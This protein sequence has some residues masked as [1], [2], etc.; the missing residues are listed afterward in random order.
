M[1]DQQI[2]TSDLL[3][4]IKLLKDKVTAFESGE[5]YQQIQK[6][7]RRIVADRDRQ[8]RQLKSELAEAH[9]ETVD[10][11]NRWFQTCEDIT[12]EKEAALTAKDRELKKMEKRM[13]EAEHQR[14][15]YKDKLHQ[16]TLEL[17]AAQTKVEELQGTIQKLTAEINRDYTNSGMSSSM[18]PNHI[19]IQNGREKTGKKPG[20][21]EGHPHHGRKRLEPDR[22]VQI[23]VPEE[24]L[25]SSKY[26]PTGKNV[27]K[28]VIGFRLTP[29]VIDYET[30]E[31]I[32]LATGKHVHAEFPEGVRDDVNYDGSVK[33][34]AYYL[35]NKCNVSIG[36]THSFIK[37]ASGGKLDLSSGM[38]C[39]LAKEFSEKTQEER[40]EIFR[41]LLASPAM[42]TD[43]TF[44]RVCG[45]TAAVMVCAAGDLVLY[46]GKEK[47]GHEGVKGTP[48]ELYQNIII[49]DHESTF[50]NYGTG[51]QECLVHVERYLRSSIENDPKRTWDEEMLNWIKEA[52]H[53]WNTCRESGEEPAAGKAADFESRYKAIIGKAR[54]EY[55][56]EP[57]DKYFKDGYNLYKRL[58]EYK[59]DYL[60]FLH[61]SDV[62]PTNNAA[63]RAGR[64]Y[65]R[66]SAAAMG[67]RSM[68]GHNYYCDGLTIMMTMQSKGENIF[69]G[70][71][72]RF[73]RIMTEA[74]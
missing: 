62:A 24:F 27:C 72:T 56:Y 28:Q 43:F 48:V 2:R 47:K 23:P 67:F 18:K 12:A 70:L 33:G 65:K 40:N 25:D 21:Q 9:A 30:P 71:T 54:E 37:E 22:K 19:K 45:N 52:I 3:F 4:N 38:I 20:A 57:A 60:L 55:E 13:Y 64:K 58:S 32:C 26:R 42:H 10:V 66:K 36:N 8:I 34:M 15:E 31:F 74:K 44:G 6:E 7:H 50:L 53:Y 5:K 69:E 16:K 41:S 1:Y 73:G 11:R 61:N 63:E 29:V 49:S 39:Q 68:A 59:E 14:N 35:N 46:Q 51:H 17:Y